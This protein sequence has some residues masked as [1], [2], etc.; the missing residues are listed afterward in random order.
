MTRQASNNFR[1]LVPLL[2]PVRAEQPYCVD[3]RNFMVRTDGVQSAFGFRCFLAQPGAIPTS[4]TIDGRLP[5]LQGVQSLRSIFGT[6]YYCTRNG[7]FSYHE[8][9]RW[10]HP[11]WWYEESTK[12][13]HPWTYA[14]VGSV[15]YFA[16]KGVNIIAHSVTEDFWYELA[17]SSDTTS[18]CECGGRLVVVTEELIKWSAVANGE[19]MAPDPDTG[20]GF[21]VLY[22][23]GQ[24]CY[25]YGDGVLTYTAN[26]IFRSALTNSAVVFRHLPFYGNEFVPFNPWCVV[27]MPDNT[28]VFLTDHGFYITDGNKAPELWQPL[29]SEFF[30]DL[31][32]LV[33]PA[34]FSTAIRLTSLQ[35][36]RIIAVSIVPF[37]T[38]N[39]WLFEDAWIYHTRTDQWGSLNRF[40]YGLLE[41][42]FL[43]GEFL[44]NHAGFIDEHGDF[45]LFTHE[46]SIND[47]ATAQ[48]V[49]HDILD[50][51]QSRA[52]GQRRVGSDIVMD[53]TVAVYSE[54][55]VT[56]LRN[57]AGLYGINMEE[58]VPGT[59]VIESTVLD[60]NTRLGPFR[61]TDIEEISRLYELDEIIVHSGRVVTDSFDDYNKPFDRA[62][63]IDFNL[64]NGEEDYGQS[65]AITAQY[66]LDVFPTIDGKTAQP[67]N[68]PLKHVE[69]FKEGTSRRFVL[70]TQGIYHFLDFSVVVPGGNYSIQT[71]EL[72]LMPRG[73]LIG[74]GMTN[75]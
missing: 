67:I 35:K 6:I 42:S 55:E 49:N 68:Y 15:E 18:I 23:A 31:Q 3:G 24:I 30:A 33:E 72:S 65:S 50:F 12:Y 63:F 56:S 7:I 29:M 22:S 52:G 19:D 66:H 51:R 41:Y 75:A 20:A 16:T 36:E 10:L 39:P 62:I 59:D 2:D 17:D 32:E 54:P 70:G 14:L 48:P 28:Q 1:G 57:I 64:L 47:Y 61:L 74:A 73:I 27:E 38:Q 21:Q 4:K 71:T 43:L 5:G 37:D 9:E 34:P 26:G 46:S 13:I 60:S 44:G 11:H 53:A 8:R 25:S 40:H 45:N 69:D 58:I